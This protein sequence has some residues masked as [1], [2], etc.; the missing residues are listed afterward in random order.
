MSFWKQLFGGT[1]G[2]PAKTTLLLEEL[3]KL[4][5]EKKEGPFG[6]LLPARRDDWDALVLQNQDLLL[7]DI[8]LAIEHSNV[9]LRRSAI[10]LLGGLHRLKP[11]RMRPTKHIVEALG[12][13]L[14]G[15][16]EVSSVEAIRAIWD[17]VRLDE[18][19]KSHIRLIQQMI[20][21]AQNSTYSE[22]R[23]LASLVLPD[24]RMN[25][26]S[27]EGTG[28]RGEIR[29][30]GKVKNGERIKIYFLEDGTAEVRRGLWYDRENEENYHL[31]SGNVSWKQEG[32]KLHIEFRY[33]QPSGE[34][35]AKFDGQIR[36]DSINGMLTENGVTYD[37]GFLSGT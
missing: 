26:R 16:D 14:L 27:L 33:A 36:P 18:D 10:R 24:L 12:R 30:I 22:T 15:T 11:E 20:E 9:V 4:D 2:C 32:E 19:S 23:R 25:V 5:A 37:L 21:Q 28:W 35:Y 13:V 3:E 34:L 6:L 31:A 17:F 29:E 8:H 7:R 1:D